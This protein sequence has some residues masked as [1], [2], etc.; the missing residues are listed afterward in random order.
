MLL[1]KA[2][3]TMKSFK[4]ILLVALKSILY[5]FGGKTASTC[6]GQGRQSF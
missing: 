6:H 4:I 3:A 1:W 2:I 5:S